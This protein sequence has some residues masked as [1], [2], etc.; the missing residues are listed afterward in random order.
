MSE[1]RQFC[2]V[3]KASEVLAERWTPLV[4]RELLCGSRRFNDLRRGV[5]VMSPSLLAQRLRSLEAVGVVRSYASPSGHGREYALT[6]AGEAL[7]PIIEM[8]GFWG[9]RWIMGELTAKDFDP[10]LLMWDM[11][12]RMQLGHLPG[13]RVVVQFNF[14]NAPKGKRHW[15]LVLEKDSVDVCLTAPGY[16]VGLTIATDPR[17]MCEVWLGERTFEAARRAGT[18][19]MEG[20]RE[21]QRAFPKW[22]QLSLFAP[23][24]AG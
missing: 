6:P 21:L 7:R 15:W 2:P 12:R 17:T 8:L 3:A 11:R 9:R 1:Y 4:V 18:I 5:P 23:S 22:M 16:E 10:A 19:K 24:I 13:D 20:P 14:T